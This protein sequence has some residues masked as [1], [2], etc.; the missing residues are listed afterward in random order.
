MVECAILLSYWECEVSE[1]KRICFVCLGNIVRSPLAEHMFRH[2]AEQAG[3]GYKYEVESAGTSAWHVGE[4]P[5]ARM[6]RVAASYGLRYDGRAR[7]F[8]R[9]D[10]DRYDLI[11]AMDRDNRATLASMA[12][13]PEQRTRIRLLR[14]FDPQGDNHAAVPDPYYGGIDGFERTYAIVERAVQGLLQVLE[15]GE[16]EE[17][18]TGKPSISICRSIYAVYPLFTMY[19]F[20]LLHTR[21]Y[22]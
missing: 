7:Q 15:N 22:L 9:D 14:E 3:V 21:R 20:S 18:M 16:V 13:T 5:D 6:Q 4:Q 2:Q 10:L 19:T 12:R 8:Q 11:I 17:G 1:I